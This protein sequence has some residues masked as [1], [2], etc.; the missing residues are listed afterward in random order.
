MKGLINLVMTD[1]EGGKEGE[2]KGGLGGFA[3]S[4]DIDDGESER[5][6]GGA[7]DGKEVPRALGVGVIGEAKMIDLG[8]VAVERGEGRRRPD[9]CRGHSS[10]LKASNRP[11]E[12]K[13]GR[14]ASHGDVERIVPTLRSVNPSR[15]GN[16]RRNR[17]AS[18]GS[19][20]SSVSDVIEGATARIIRRRSSSDSVRL[21]DSGLVSSTPGSRDASRSPSWQPK[22]VRAEWARNERWRRFGRRG[23]IDMVYSLAANVVC[24]PPGRSGHA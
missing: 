1:V 2:G 10:R 12:T 17:A 11:S 14:R 18:S 5:V 24:R 20:A 3:A 13:A 23:R 19:N 8:R 15:L 6:D 21:I 4:G 16:W 9:I 7:K 22:R